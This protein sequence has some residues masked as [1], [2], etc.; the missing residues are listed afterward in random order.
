MLSIVVIPQKR[1]HSL[2][3]SCVVFIS[4]CDLAVR[5]IAKGFLFSHPTEKQQTSLK[6]SAH[7]HRT[8]V[9]SNNYNFL[10]P[11]KRLWL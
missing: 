11:P 7:P 1:K 3:F 10:P 2:V 9:T 8:G 4:K 5:D 6:G